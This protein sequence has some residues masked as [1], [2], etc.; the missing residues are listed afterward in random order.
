MNAYPQFVVVFA[1]LSVTVLSPAEID[2]GGGKSSGGGLSSH[3]SIGSPFSTFTTSGCPISN[4]PGLIEVLY[5]VLPDSLTDS[6]SSGLPDVW[7]TKHFQHLGVDPLA[8]EDHDGSTNLMEYLA[9]TDPNSGTCFF[10]PQGSYAAGVFQMP[11]QTVLG[12]TYQI[13]VSRDLQEWTLQST[14]TGNNSVQLFEFDETTIV[15]GPLFSPVHPSKYFFRV[16]IL[17]P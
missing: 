10:H 1:F 11:I 4:H 8:D 14:F 17:M 7:E 12:R 3:S 6:D 16:Q 5:P 9:G 15:S 13:W 2:S